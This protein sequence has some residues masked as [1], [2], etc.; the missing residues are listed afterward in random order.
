LAQFRVNRSPRIDTAMKIC[1]AL[2]ETLD[3]FL[4][5]G[6]DPVTAEILFHLDQLSDEER[7]LLLAAARGLRAVDPEAEP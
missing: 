7:R 1:H 5:K 4:T 6:R 2:G 3:S